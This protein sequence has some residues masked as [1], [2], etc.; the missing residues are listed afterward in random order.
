MN[1]PGIH[2]RSGL[3]F[4]LGRSCTERLTLGRLPR[5]SSF[6]CEFSTAAAVEP[7]SFVSILFVPIL[8]RRGDDF[9][10]RE[11]AAF[12][13][14]ESSIRVFRPSKKGNAK[15]GCSLKKV[16][17]SAGLSSKKGN[18]E[19]GCQA[20]CIPCRLSM[21]ENVFDGRGPFRAKFGMLPPEGLEEMHASEL[22]GVPASFRLVLASA[23]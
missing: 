1:R 20:P 6:K 13:R 16:T 3:R 10:V 19:C 22:L 15:C 9:V 12:S 5:R 21:S 14:S 2:S 11:T 4:S 18:A 23:A 8:W 17:P 7:R